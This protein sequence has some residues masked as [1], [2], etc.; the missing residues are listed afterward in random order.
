NIDLLRKV[1]NEASAF[2]VSR[3]ACIVCDGRIRSCVGLQAKTC[4]ARDDEGGNK[5]SSHLSRGWQD[6]LNSHCP[7]TC[8]NF[9][10]YLFH[11]DAKMGPHR[12][13]HD[14]PKWDWNAS[15]S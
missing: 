2:L 15:K 11:P 4:P 12:E 10:R 8:L 3:K 5:D 1:G 6:V 9:K 13:A 14:A 7:P